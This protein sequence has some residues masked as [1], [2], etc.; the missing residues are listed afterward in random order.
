MIASGAEPG[1]VGRVGREHVRRSAEKVWLD[2][3]KN[4]Y[5]KREADVER[6]FR[7]TLLRLA[8]ESAGSATPLMPVSRFAIAEA[9]REAVATLRERN[10]LVEIPAD[11]RP[12]DA[13][14]SFAAR[15]VA[16]GAVLQVVASQL[17][18]EDET[19]GVRLHDRFYLTRRYSHP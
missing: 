9:V 12:Y 5:R 15:Y 8:H 16:A 11:F 2:G 19:M 7:P 3:T 6:W 13:R 14:H 4:G 10:P 17:G 1:V 18:H